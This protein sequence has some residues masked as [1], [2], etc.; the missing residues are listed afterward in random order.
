MML[1]CIDDVWYT[2]GFLGSVEFQPLVLFGWQFYALSTVLLAVWG[3]LVKSSPGTEAVKTVGAV[4]HP[5]LVFGRTA[6]QPV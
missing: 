5:P 3:V 1:T 4:V 6:Q 2:E